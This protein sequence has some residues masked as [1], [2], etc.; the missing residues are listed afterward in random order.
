MSRTEVADGLGKRLGDFIGV[1]DS[2]VPTVR[3][4]VPGPSMKKFTMTEEITVENL[5]KFFDDFTAGKLT[6]ILKSEPIPETN[7]K[8]VKVVVGKSFN[9]VVMDETK[10]VLVKFYAPW[11]GH[12]KKMAPDYEKAAELIRE[13]NPNIVIADFDAT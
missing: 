8:A 2:E 3:I 1:K 7:D 13:K 11:C 4:V 10:D 9:D 6:N 5:V 12:C